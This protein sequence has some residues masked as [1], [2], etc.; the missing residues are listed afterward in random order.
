MQ[1]LQAKLS[2][3]ADELSCS[4]TLGG[5]K[6]LAQGSPGPARAVSQYMSSVVAC[7]SF[8]HRKYCV[9][10]CRPAA[11]SVEGVQQ[12]VGCAQ[13]HRGTGICGGAGSRGPKPSGGA[14]SGPLR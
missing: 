5:V 6:E 10:P 14:L 1:P 12:H 8:T 2:N 4:V 3:S 11:I 9:L 13:P 7:R